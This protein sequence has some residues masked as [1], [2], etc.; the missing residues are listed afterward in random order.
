MVLSDD[1]LR[2]DTS[3]GDV[4]VNLIAAADR[5]GKLVSI[6]KLDTLNDLSLVGDSGTDLIDGS[7][8]VVIG[9]GTPLPSRLLVSDGTLTWDI[10]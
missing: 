10:I 9:P 1:H 2:A 5:K 8:V 3:S 4:I 7:N 6:K